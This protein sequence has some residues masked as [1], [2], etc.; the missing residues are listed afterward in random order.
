MISSPPSRAMCWLLNHSS[1]S[2]LKTA[3]LE[4]MPSSENAATS[5]SR[6]NS[7]RSFAR[8][9]PEQREEVEHRLGQEALPLVLHHRRRAVPLAQ[10]P[11]VGAE[12]QRHVREAR[13]RRAERLVEQHL[14]RRVR[15]VIVAAD[16]VGDPHV[17]VVDDDRQVIGR[18]A[19]RPQDDEVLDHRVVEL[20]P[21]VHHVVV[22]RRARRACGSGS[23]AA[24]PAA[25]RAAIS[26]RRER[27]A[28]AV[29]RPRLPRLLGRLALR[30][31]LV[32]VAVAVVGV[33]R[34]DQALG[35][36][37][38]AVEPLRLE[39][40]ARAGRRPPGPRPSRGRA[41]AS[42]RGCRPPSPTTSARRR[43]P[44]CAGRRCRRAWRA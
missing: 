34:R 15:D 8:R 25:S 1:F 14:L 17:D 28:R 40:R 44:R 29:V 23:R 7:S 6:V 26:S 16:D 36:L 11:L 32:G 10:P 9:P 43:C 19:V 35:R 21:P 31:D 18:V 12:D 4:L 22:R 30:L 13:H 27:G 24:R 20:D 2:G 38:V 42:R 39:V 3:L 5:S 33:A 41:T 37:A